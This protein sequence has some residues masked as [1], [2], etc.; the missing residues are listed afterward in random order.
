[1]VPNCIPLVQSVAN[2]ILQA[3]NMHSVRAKSY[4]VIAII[5]ILST[6]LLV[7]KYGIIGAAIPTGVAYL[8]GQGLIMNW[9]YW[10][11]VGL[12][13]LKFWKNLLPIFMVSI[14]LCVLTLISTQWID[15]SRWSILFLGIT[16]YTILYIVLVWKFVL[17]ANEKTMVKS[18]L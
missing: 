9:Y 14:A 12:N 5:N 6:L 8:L 13:I 11:K 1:M 15:F 3:K 18:V 2:S 17:N 10:K 7:Q 4:L 16:C